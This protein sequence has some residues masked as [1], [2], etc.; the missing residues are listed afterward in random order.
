MQ[1]QRRSSWVMAAYAAPSLP[2]AALGLPLVVYLPNHYSAS[3]GL[4]VSAVGA[5]F[6]LVRLIDIIFDPIFGT[7]LDRT[8]WQAGRF[9]PWLSIGAPMIMLATWMLFMAQPG[10]GL[11]YLWLW[12]CVLYGGYS[13]CI[14]SHSAWGSTLS[15][16]YN[17]RSR[18]YAW[19]QSGN[20]VGM[21]LVLMLPVALTAIPQATIR[22]VPAMGWFIVLLI[23]LAVGVALSAVPEPRR[24]AAGEVHTVSLKAYF[25]LIRRPTIA[26]ILFADL[27]L[28]IGPGVA[29]AL[30][31]FYFEHIK[32]YSKTEAE[33][34]LLIYFISAIVGAPIWAVVSKRIGKHKALITAAIVYA[35]VQFAI[36]F[37]PNT[38]LLMALP[39]LVAAGLPYSSAG[40]LLRAMLADA[41]DEER[42]RTGQDRTGTLYAILT[43]TIKVGMALSVGS[44]IILGWVGFNAQNPAASAPLAL[45]GLEWMYA[46]LPGG[47]ALLAAWV[48]AR[49]PLTEARHAEIRQ[50]LA[51]IDRA[52]PAA[53]VSPAAHAVRS[54][55]E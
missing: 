29:G 27:L 48:L 38:G 31:F 43:G 49:Y 53:Q 16:D 55:A 44:F 37:V 3:L 46:A 50:K 10:V 32:G 26:R 41:G 2:L 28:H 52:A 22:G 39:F 51:E 20:V 47:F 54:P 7:I 21:I 9:R 36:P 25:D 17:E 19:W 24:P 4:S 18:I 12:L 35:A 1:S 14:L 13:I 34:L 33:T 42:L 23:P 8:R 15:E 30:F 40:V 45:K 11:G 6:L 5:A